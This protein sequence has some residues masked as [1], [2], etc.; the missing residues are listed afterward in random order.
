M[1]CLERP[2]SR[3]FHFCA[4]C[5][6]LSANRGARLYFWFG[7]YKNFWICYLF[8]AAYWSS[9]ISDHVGPARWLL[10]SCKSWWCPPFVCIGQGVEWRSCW[11]PGLQLRPY[12]TGSESLEYRCC[13]DLCIVSSSIVCLLYW[14]HTWTS[15]CLRIWRCRRG[16]LAS[17][18]SC[19][20]EPVGWDARLTGWT[21]WK[22]WAQS[23]ALNQHPSETL[24]WPGSFAMANW[25]AAAVA[26]VSLHAPRCSFLYQ[27]LKDYFY[28][29]CFS[30]QQLLLIAKTAW[31][32][33]ISSRAWGTTATQPCQIY[34]C[35][36]CT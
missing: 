6:I 21:L 16:H 5:K 8:V 14:R 26:Q 18:S 29:P 36:C 33:W 22:H 12:S 15:C 19:W 10:S 24:I 25:K 20:S 30:C 1:D 35:R 4:V 17:E 27:R 2:H 28:G 11:C 32:A 23:A 9:Q 34:L 3:H 31:H 13:L 7:V